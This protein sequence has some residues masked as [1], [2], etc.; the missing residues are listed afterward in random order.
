[1]AEQ[2]IPLANG[3]TIVV[4][5]D[6]RSV[7]L[8]LADLYQYNLIDQGSTISKGTSG[9]YIEANPDDLIY[10]TTLGWFIVNR[11]DRTNHVVYL[12]DWALPKEATEVGADDVLLGQGP[13]YQSETW[14][15]YFDNRVFPYRLQI[16]ARSRMYSAG[17]M[18]I[19]KGVDITASGEI[20]GQYYDQ[21]DTFQG[22]EIPLQLTQSEDNNNR[23]F[24][25][26]VTAYTTTPLK[27]GDVV[28][29]VFYSKSGAQ[30]SLAKLLI[31]ETSLTRAIGTSAKYVT[32]IELVSPYLSKT[33]ASVLELPLNVTASTLTLQ[34]KVTYSDGSSKL[35]PVTTDSGAKFALFGLD[36]WTP[37]TQGQV[38]EL[39][40]RYLFSDDE[41]SMVPEITANGGMTERY[42]VKATQYNNSY[43]VKLFA[44]PWWV[45]ATTGY[46]LTYWLF[47]L[48]RAAFYRLA[49]GLVTLA[50]DSASFDPLNYTN[51][52]TLK[53]TVDLSKVSSSYIAHRHVQSI[54]IA[55]KAAGSDRTS[56]WKVKPVATAKVWFGDKLEAPLTYVSANSSTINLKNGFATKAEWLQ[57]LYY[58]NAPIFNPRSEVQAPEPTH[59]ILHTAARQYERPI[60]DWANDLSVT[61]DLTDGQVLFIRWIKR[62]PNTDLQL[63]VSGLP[64]HQVN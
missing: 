30:M 41:Y 15:C 39:T 28:T 11:V 44:F 60:S 16:D 19:F 38:E 29:A 31:K 43:S 56:N 37:S 8:N 47:D 18:V 53:V 64:L 21:N 34:G 40:L 59:F 14:R 54:A 27:N 55:L 3:D 51:V 58:N 57:A 12:S 50:N 1:M 35:L 4:N 48:D 2:K 46:K 10:S 45:N 49:D 24:F 42:T 13:G 62:M 32:S 63:G 20:I 23:L 22:H 7:T 61:K 36:G 26:P 17:T 6:R 5:E 52:Q 25:A 9:A 33:D